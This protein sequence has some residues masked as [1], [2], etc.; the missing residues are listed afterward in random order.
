MFYDE[1]CYNE[2]I[3][4]QTVF[5]NKIRIL[6]EYRCYNE[7]GGI[8]S[9][10]VA[11]ACAGACRAFPFRLERQSSSSLSFVRFSYQ[12]SSVIWL[13]APL[14]VKISFSLIILLYNFSHE[15]VN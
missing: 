4:Q 13:F 2:Q 9:A 11:R 14:E 3:L 5:I 6:N 15:P 8:L 12:F 1:P 7:R 10:D